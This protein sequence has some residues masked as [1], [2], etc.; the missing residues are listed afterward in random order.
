MPKK[1]KKSEVAKDDGVHYSPPGTKY[2][3]SQIILGRKYRHR[4]SGTEGWA[5]SITFFENACERVIL[6]SYERNKLTGKL[7]TT[8]SF[9]SVELVDAET[10][11]DVSTAKPGGPE[12]EIAS[13]REA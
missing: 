9:D 11:D 7:T 1:T 8:E 6:E 12:R 13:R 3:E 2:Y 4:R 5:T 10:G